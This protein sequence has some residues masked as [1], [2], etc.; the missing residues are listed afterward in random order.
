MDHKEMLIK[1]QRVMKINA[2]TVEF[3]DIDG[4]EADHGERQY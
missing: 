4:E 2:K 3:R 1:F